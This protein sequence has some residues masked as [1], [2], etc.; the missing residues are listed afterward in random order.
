MQSV[1]V[2]MRG[3]NDE[4]ARLDAER[5]A[6]WRRSDIGYTWSCDAICRTNDK[7]MTNLLDFLSARTARM[8]K[9]ER[10]CVNDV[11]V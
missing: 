9:P 11:R 1:A 4:I 6:V 3:D 8:I 10:R 5:W 2:C 7:P